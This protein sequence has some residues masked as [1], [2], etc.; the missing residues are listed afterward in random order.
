MKTPTG[1]LSL[2]L[3][4]GDQIPQLGLGVFKVDDGECERVVLDALELGYRHIDTAM[5]YRNEAAVGR[6]IA[7]SGIARDDLFVTTKLWNVDQGTDSTEDAL[8][9]SLGLLGL[10]YVDLYLIHWPAPLRERYVE[11]WLLLEGMV[12]AGHTRAIGVSNFEPGHLEKI[13][14]AGST[15]PA[16]N[17]VEL[18]PAFQQRKARA[19]GDDKGILTEA[20]GPLG[21]GKYELAELPGLNEI[22]AKTG[23]TIQ[24]VVLRW[25][26]QEGVIVFPKSVRKERL[27][28]NLDVF[29]FV[30]DAEDM[31]TMVAMDSGR[32]VGTH[33]D[34]GN[35]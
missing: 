27:A 12:A 17:Q 33:P 26:L 10:D 25:H 6:A 4:T 18:H 30:L 28:E 2:T 35:W 31:A 34:D 1:Q 5:I 7:K 14:E 19:F 29:D 8:K 16:V 20:W 3:N 9:T 15:I 11:T 22:A 13:L 24:Q 32:R 21:Q 23:K